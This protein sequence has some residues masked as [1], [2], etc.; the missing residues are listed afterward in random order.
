MYD[1]TYRVIIIGM[2]KLYNQRGYSGFEEEISSLRGSL[3][4]EGW[5]PQ[6]SF[7]IAL[8]VVHRFLDKMNGDANTRLFSLRP[9]HFS[10][11]VKECMEKSKG[12]LAALKD[13]EDSPN[14]P[15]AY[16]RIFR[17]E[18]PSILQQQIKED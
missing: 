10:D 3:L 1:V 9:C 7:D 18:S 16:S 4:R 15:W 11:L 17:T 5:I 14:S 13:A 2:Y 6:I 12:F 8:K